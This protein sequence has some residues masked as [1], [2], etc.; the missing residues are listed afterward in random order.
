MVM[1]SWHLP[2]HQSVQT[3]QL[4]SWLLL[5]TK[6][7]TY[8]FFILMMGMTWTCKMQSPSICVAICTGWIKAASTYS[9]FLHAYEDT[10]RGNIRVRHTRA[11]C[12]AC[13][14][15]CRARESGTQCECDGQTRRTG[16]SSCHETRSEIGVVK[17]LLNHIY[18]SVSLSML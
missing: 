6:R 17:E 2:L 9:P 10:E 3:T 7:N 12:R 14:I 15:R 18:I 1:R 8:I 11:R 5:I 16:E 4:T 13:D